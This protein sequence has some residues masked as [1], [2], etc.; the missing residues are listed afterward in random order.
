[1]ESRNQT[2]VNALL[3]ALQ[4]TLRFEQEISATF[5]SYF[6]DNIS[7]DNSPSASKTLS[8]YGL[9]EAPEAPKSVSEG[10]RR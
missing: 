4:T 2:D 7:D 9:P 3:K 5:E 1:M 6:S 10:A 8:P